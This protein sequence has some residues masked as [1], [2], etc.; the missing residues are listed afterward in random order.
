MKKIIINNEM[1][2]LVY[3][4]QL[5]DPSS[6]VA[7][8]IANNSWGLAEREVESVPTGYESRVIKTETRIRP[9]TGEEYTVYTLKADYVITITD[10]TDELAKEKALQDTINL[11]RLARGCCADIYDYIGAKIDGYTDEQINTFISTYSEILQLVQ[12]NRQISVKNAVYALSASELLT[13]EMID[14]VKAIIAKY[15]F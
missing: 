8:C 2:G 4:A 1:N 3:G 5:E 14:G 7:I 12:L 15:G 11:G 9:H 13:Q 10:I 6:W